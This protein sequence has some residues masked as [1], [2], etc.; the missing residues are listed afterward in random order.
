MKRIYSL[1]LVGILAFIPIWAQQSDYYYYYKGE[2]IVLPVDSTRLYVV[3]EGELQTKN[4]ASANIRMANCN[5]NGSSKSNVYNQVVPLQQNRTTVPEVY[6]STLEVP[7][8]INSSQYDALIGKMK[9]EDAVWQVL[10]SFSINGEQ[11][12]VTNNFYVKLKSEVDFGI[13]QEMS[14]QYN[15]EIIGHHEHMPLWYILSCNSSSALNSLEAANL[16]YTSGKFECSEPEFN[17]AI[18]FY[19]DD[20]RFI[21]QWNLK[22]TG[23]VAGYHGV[24]INVEEAWEITKGEGAIVAIYD[25]AIS[26]SHSDLSANILVNEGYDIKTGTIPVFN[27]STSGRHGMHSAGVIAAIQDNGIGLTGVAPESKIMSIA[28]SMAINENTSNQNIVKVTSLEISLGFTRACQKADVI[29]CPWSYTGTDTGLIDSAINTA[30]DKCVIVFASGNYTRNSSYKDIPY[31]ANSNPRILTVGGITSYGNRLTEGE[32]TSSYSDVSS[33]YGEALDVVAPAVSIQTT[34][35]PDPVY[36]QD[37]YY[38]VF[39]GTSAAC[40]HVS[41]VA[42][43]ILSAHPELTPDQVVSIIE[44][45]ARKI[46]PDLYTYQVDSLRP[47]GTWNEEMGY[48]LV[49]AGAAVRIADKA[50]RTTYI[51]DMVIGFERV[52]DYDIEI[53]NIVVTDGGLLDIDKERSVFLKRNVHIEKGGTMFIHKDYMP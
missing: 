49:D 51:R 3:S 13:L 6:F 35:F 50:S 18:T 38:G 52:I 4:E 11:V 8:E 10:P 31:P 34:H 36:S 26:T 47:Y 33:R 29:N 37:N 44:Y 15:I 17:A 2:R 23:Q 1:L 40:A 43:L 9:S 32:T 28:C 21:N 53:E 42:A 27:S 14:S 12:D 20:P 7:K 24:D 45:T 39:C 19:S 22:N 5:V 41:A 48:G 16:F 25:E 46:R 30:L